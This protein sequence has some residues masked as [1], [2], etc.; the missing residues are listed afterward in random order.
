MRALDAGS[1]RSSMPTMKPRRRTSRDRGQRRDALEQLARAASIF[2]CEPLQR[3]L[4]LEHVER[5]QRRRARQRVARV[6][7][8]VE[9]G[10]ELLVLAEEALVDL[11]RWP[12][13]R[14]AAGSRR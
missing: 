7:V 12:A 10:P 8:A 4:L 2:G 3:A 9:E 1:S 13:W 14:R 6:G 11:A 5:G